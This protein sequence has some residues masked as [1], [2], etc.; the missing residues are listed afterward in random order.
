MTLSGVQRMR[1]IKWAV[2]RE[3]CRRHPG[4]QGGLC[5][6]FEVTEKA[7][8][9]NLKDIQATFGSADGVKVKSGKPVVVFNIGG[10]NFRLIAAVHY[11]TQTVYTLMVLAHRAYEKNRW[12]DEL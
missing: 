5:H 10:D 8:W 2:L 3:F 11:N 7:E 9:Q 1:I 12:K 4:A 6:L